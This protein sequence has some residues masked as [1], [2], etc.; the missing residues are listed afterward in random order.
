[1]AQSQKILVKS[2]WSAK[3]GKIP[4]PKW[5]ETGN[6][7]RVVEFFFNGNFGESRVMAFHLGPGC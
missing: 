4:T 2:F 7:R 1:M 5:R 3:S 6:T